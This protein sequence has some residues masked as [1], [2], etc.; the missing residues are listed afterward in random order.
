MAVYSSGQAD[1][2]RT[3]ELSPITLV[4]GIAGGIPGGVLPVSALLP[5][6]AILAG[7]AGDL[8]SAFAYFQPLPGSSLIDNALGEY[9]FANLAVAAN[10]IVK[11]PLMV[12]M[13][14]TIPVKS[15]FSYPQK[16]AVMKALQ[17][18]LANHC[19]SGGTFIVA[20][21][22]YYYNNCIL[23][24][25][26]DISAGETGQAQYSWKWD[27]RRPLLSAEGASPGLNSFMA[28]L[29]SGA[30]APEATTGRAL[31]T[32]RS[33]GAPAILPPAAATASAGVPSQGA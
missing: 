29:S 31:Q 2:K 24:G 14:M 26:H 13:L 19:A 27:F 5:G 21:P 11:Q 33:V 1:F 23:V 7:A 28:A 4:G 15:G 30:M 32:P 10:A 9:P 17:N 18:T 12:S 20:T 25:L 6:G 8:D 16:L 22:S 3:F